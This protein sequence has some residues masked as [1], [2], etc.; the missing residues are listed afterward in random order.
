MKRRFFWLISAL[1]LALSAPGIVRAQM[2]SG[3]LMQLPD[4]EFLEQVKQGRTEEVNRQIIRGQ[5]PN[6]SD[7]NSR[8][9]LMYAAAGGYV[10]IIQLLVKN[11]ANLRMKDKQGNSALY[12][13]VASGHDEAVEALLQLGAPPNDPD[14]QGTTPLMVASR[15]G[16]EGAV[17]QLL[18]AKADVNLTDHTGRTA[19][20]WS[21]ESRNPQVQKLL[22][23][24][25]AR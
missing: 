15:R 4:T 3:G 5:S 23:A 16:F 22:L 7:A 1:L 13:A 24:A 17:R 2:G 8:T 6:T 25:G 10:D 14:R 12:W 11:K 9:A 18:A 20:M 19:L 21:K